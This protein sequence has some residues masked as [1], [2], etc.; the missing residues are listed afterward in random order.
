[1]TDLVEVK[2]STMPDCDVCK[3]EGR[4]PTV[5]AYDGKTVY[6]PWAYMCEDHFHMIGVGLGMGRGQRLVL[7]T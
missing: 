7:R 3:H 4:E 1:M 5:A 6:G 2:M